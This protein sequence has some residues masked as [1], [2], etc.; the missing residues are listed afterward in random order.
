MNRLQNLNWFHGLSSCLIASAISFCDKKNW[1]KF[2]AKRINSTTVK[3]QKKQVWIF[4]LIECVQ[5]NVKRINELPEFLQKI[6]V[7][8]C[9]FILTALENIEWWRLFIIPNWTESRIYLKQHF[10]IATVKFTKPNEHKSIVSASE[11][12]NMHSNVR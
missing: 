1:K 4:F 2:L 6:A 7:Y 11:H 9:V 5:T 12:Q 8:I 3:K 10:C